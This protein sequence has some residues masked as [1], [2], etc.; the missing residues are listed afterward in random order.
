MAHIK[1]GNIEL[2]DWRYNTSL[3][4][5]FRNSDPT[6]DD[7]GMVS[8]SKVSLYTYTVRFSDDLEFLGDIFDEK[9]FDEKTFDGSIR[10]IGDAKMQV[11]DFLIRMSKLTSFI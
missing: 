5:W 8:I 2:R 4:Y 11:D 1:I 9:T 3:I 10:S 6:N 7:Y